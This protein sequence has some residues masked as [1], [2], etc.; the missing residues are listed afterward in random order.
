MHSGG[1][2]YHNSTSSVQSSLMWFLWSPV[3]IN[4]VH[5]QSSLQESCRLISTGPVYSGKQGLHQHQSESCNYLVSNK[6]LLFISSYS[7]F[8]CV[9]KG[10]HSTSPFFCSSCCIL[11]LDLHLPF[12]VSVG[13]GKSSIQ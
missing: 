12:A 3:I 4:V 7:H 13:P 5:I 1:S 8:F 9:S 11:K 2:G 10:A 6:M